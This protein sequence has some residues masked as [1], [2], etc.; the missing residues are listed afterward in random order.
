[1]NKLTDSERRAGPERIAFIEEFWSP[2]GWI[3]LNT[4]MHEIRNR[5]LLREFPVIPPSESV[6]VEEVYQYAYWTHHNI[7]PGGRFRDCIEYVQFMTHKTDTEADILAKLAYVQLPQEK[8]PTLSRVLSDYHCHISLLW[9]AFRNMTRA[10]LWHAYLNM[11][12]DPCGSE[13]KIHLIRHIRAKRWFA[14]SGVEAHLGAR[15]KEEGL[16]NLIG[17]FVSFEIAPSNKPV[18]ARRKGKKRSLKDAEGSATK[19]KRPDDVD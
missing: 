13:A 9:F 2:N 5:L 6:T 7:I 10:Q 12:A 14:S 1:M 3:T 16:V 11:P 4:R 8:E 19:R 18:F 17:Q 15:L